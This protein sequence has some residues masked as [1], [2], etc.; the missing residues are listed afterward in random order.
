MF[1][2]LELPFLRV[3]VFWLVSL[4]GVKVKTCPALPKGIFHDSR[5]V[6]SWGQMKGFWKLLS[7]LEVALGCPSSSTVHPRREEWAPVA[8]LG[9]Y[10]TI[11]Q[12]WR[13]SFIGNSDQ[14][15]RGLRLVGSLEM[16]TLC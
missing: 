11:T 5:F 6:S 8:Y 13:S 2:A 15:R 9:S 7:L 16:F 3:L 10:G 14:V 12:V 1:A 4:Y